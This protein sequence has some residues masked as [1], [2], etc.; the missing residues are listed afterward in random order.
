MN[1]TP[2][3]NDPRPKSLKTPKSLIIVNTG[4]GKGKSS[5][6]FGT[7]LRGRA[8]GWRVGVVQFLKSPEWVTGEQLMAEPMGME[9]WTLGEGFTWDS[10]DLTKDEAEARAAWQHGKQLVDSGEYRLVVFDEIT[11][12]LNWGWIDADEVAETFRSRPANVSLVLT[13]RNAPQWLIDMADTV[14]EMKKVKH[15]F[16]SGIAAKKGIDY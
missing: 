6:A 12:P 11:Y 9:M 2:P 4:D 13:G 3:T 8:R 5:S 16:D 14:T 1:E 15:A 7:A 10:G